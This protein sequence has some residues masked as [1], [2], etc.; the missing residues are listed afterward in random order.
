LLRAL[1]IPS[2]APVVGHFSTLRPVKCPLDIIASA[3]I[4]LRSRPDAMYLVVGD[5][6]SRAETEELARQT[7]VADRFRFA[8]EVDHARV[9]A[10]MNLCDVIVVPSERES[11]PL[12]FREAQACGCVVL[13]SDI[14]AAREAIADG[15]T[16]VLF[17]VRSIRG[18]ADA[19]LALLDD[20]R[21][22]ERIGQQAR[23]SVLRQTARW[24]R[25][26]ADVLRRAA[27]SNRGPR[28]GKFAPFT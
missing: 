23:A 24:T 15:E 6:P 4:V 14:A 17:P 3:R 10:Y 16:G 8:G 12:V 2:H 9:P 28:S 19:T 22:R 13:A 27:T 1:R 25:A 11:L 20:R 26:Y 21:R 5:G 18:L 7:R